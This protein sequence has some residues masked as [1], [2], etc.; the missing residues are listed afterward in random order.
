MEKQNIGQVEKERKKLNLIF[1]FSAA[2][3]LHCCLLFCLVAQWLVIMEVVIGVPFSRRRARLDDGSF[4]RQ[5]TTA[6][7]WIQSVEVVCFSVFR[8]SV[9]S[10]ENKKYW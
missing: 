5:E 1:Y 7:R 3:G 10:E 4:A 2:S 6:L 8:A 9:Y